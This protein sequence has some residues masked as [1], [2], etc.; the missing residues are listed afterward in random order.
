MTAT[1]DE[2]GNVVQV[3]HGTYRLDLTPT[4]EQLDSVRAVLEARAHDD[5]LALQRIAE[6]SP[7]LLTR[8]C[9]REDI[10]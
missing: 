4:A 6:R 1:Y 3:D 9:R 8:W 5:A 7:H 2:D 10:N